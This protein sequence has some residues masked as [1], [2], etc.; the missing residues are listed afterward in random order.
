[1]LPKSQRLNLKT[2]FKWVASG[3]P[4]DTQFVKLFVKLGE[5]QNPRIGITSSS[6]VFKKAVDRNR[7]RRLVSAAIQSLYNQ[8]PENINIVALPKQAVISVKSGD[9]LMELEEVLVKEEV[10][11]R[12]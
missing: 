2:D 7:A 8:L 3:K 10:I 1:M 11:S 4:I 5:N 12:K 9:V 6:K